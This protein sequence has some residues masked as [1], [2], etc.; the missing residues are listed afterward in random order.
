MLRE[1]SRQAAF[2]LFHPV[3]HHLLDRFALDGLS[4]LW[5]RRREPFRLRQMFRRDET[6]LAGNRGTLE[7]VVEI[8]AGPGPVVL[9]QGGVRVLGEGGRGTTKGLADLLQERVAQDQDVALPVPEWWNANVED[10]HPVV[11]VLAEIAAFNGF[12]EITIRR[13]DHPDIRSLQPRP[14]QPLKFPLLQHAQE[15]A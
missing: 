1:P 8:A 2:D 3:S 15:P 4:R 5:S 10:L 12:L 7:R 6:A 9:Q 14:A 13:R 11:Q